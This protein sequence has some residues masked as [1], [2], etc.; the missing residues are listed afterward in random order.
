MERTMLRSPI[1]TEGRMRM[2]IKR[3]A[4][5]WKLQ[6]VTTHPG[7]ML[8][9]EFLLPLGLTQ[10]ALAMKLRA[11]ATRV[12]DIVHG[13]R[14][15]T[16][17]PALRLARFFGNSPEFWLNLQQMHDLSKARLELSPTIER[18]VEAYAGV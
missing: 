8:R 15:V 16:P 10:K 7:E 1:T 3:P 9:E 5:G 18:D 17:D 2:T 4:A 14:A 12:G 11:R 6:R 13:R